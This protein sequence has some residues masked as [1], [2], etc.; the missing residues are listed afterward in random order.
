MATC[1]A[2]GAPGGSGRFCTTCGNPLETAVPEQPTQVI[3]VP[4]HQQPLVAPVTPSPVIAA[5]VEDDP[6]QTQATPGTGPKKGMNWLAVALIVAFGIILI[7]L[8][9]WFFNPSGDTTT[10]SASTAA[11]TPTVTRKP[12]T[13][14]APVV[15]PVIPGPTVTVT[16]TETTTSTDGQ[17]GP[18]TGSTSG[19]GSVPAGTAGALVNQLYAAWSSGDSGSVSSL[20]T[21]NVQ[22]EFDSTFLSSNNITSV[23]NVNSS[24]TP[25]ADGT[26][27]CGNQ[28]FF[29]RDGA[30]QNESRCFTVQSIG[31]TYKITDTSG[32]QVNSE[33]H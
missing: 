4:A 30:Q 12:S 31:G 20:V 18:A 29:R 24:E 25:M 28:T 32:L 22:S 13:P 5:P 1:P 21:S 3:D 2:C 27:V 9:F 17:D 7:G 26:Q 11:P 19:G 15:P 14:T 6:Q 8:G 10:T 33:W 16:A 23:T